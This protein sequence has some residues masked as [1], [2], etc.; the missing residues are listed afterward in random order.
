MQDNELSLGQWIGTV[1]LSCIPCVNIIMLIIW[2][3]GNGNVARKRW[4]LATI[5]VSVVLCIISFIL[6]A[7]LGAS[8]AAVM[9]SMM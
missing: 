3:V 7:V 6:S 4:A 8:L 5:I 1:V 2:A 9:Q